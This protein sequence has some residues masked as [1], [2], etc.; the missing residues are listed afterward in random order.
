M[1]DLISLLSNSSR[2]L[3]GATGALQTASH[4]LQ[5]VNTPGYARQ[6]AVLRAST[7]A[8][9]GSKVWIGRGSE[10]SAVQQTRDRLLEA[11]I[12]RSYSSE[13]FHTARSETLQ[14]FHGFDP[15][16]AAGV[17]NALAGLFDSLRLLSQNAGE[18]ALRDGVVSAAKQLSIAFQ[19]AASDIE[20]TRTGIDQKLSAGI[21]E[22]NRLTSQVAALNKQI[23][24]ARKA[25]AGE[26]NDLL[27]ARQKAQ[28]RLAELVGAR[29][30]PDRDGNVSLALESGG[31][32]VTGDVPLSFRTSPDADKYGHASVFLVSANGSRQDMRAGA[33]SGE[34]GGLLS[35]R[36]STLA[37]SQER[38]DE[39]AGGIADRFNE[40]QAAGT[41]MDGLEGGPLFEVGS[42]PGIARRIK[43]SDAIAADSQL[44]ATR[45]LGL[46]AG[47][48]SIVLRMIGVE[49]EKLLTTGDTPT[50]SYAHI[51]SRFGADSRSASDSAKHNSTMR[52]H[53]ESMRE[54][55]IG[56]SIDEEL[57]EMNK[58]QRAYDAIS[59]VLSTA[60]S[61]LDTLLKLR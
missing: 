5:N 52:N 40:L 45:G 41:D 30:V 13:A 50:S 54:S 21:E 59:K 3:S 19:N 48:S 43:V 25:G 22:A 7:P 58:T 15:E 53:L 31:P 28:D 4:N 34:L 12:P 42:G 46:G 37:A 32:L 24:L 61:M 2:S 55:V 38:L 11:Q 6:R 60:D 29:P 16:Q 47:D 36:D 33:L 18:R 1:P 56:V 39:L 26:P 20:A 49:Q 44:L 35:A 51:V 57:I 17:G 14:G 8:D 27:D 10:L 23:R 9:L